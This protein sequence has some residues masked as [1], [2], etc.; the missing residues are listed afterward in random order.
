MSLAIKIATIKDC[1]AKIED[2]FKTIKA[3]LQKVD[4]SD[5]SERRN[6]VDKLKSDFKLLSVHFEAMKDEVDTIKDENTYKSYKDQLTLVKLEIK[7]LEEEFL[8]KQNK[9]Y[10]TSNLLLE[11]VNIEMKKTGQM[12]VQQAFDRGDKAVDGADK[13]INNI[14]KKVKSANEIANEIQIEQAK[15]I[16]KLTGTRKDLKEINSSLKRSDANIKTMLTMY[17]TDKL[18]MCMIVLIVL[19]IITIIIIGAVGGDTKGNFNVPH[20]IFVSNTN[21]TTATSRRL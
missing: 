5:T 9:A 21:T 11:D 12:T 19:I 18:I 2:K 4:S 1:N 7:K 14:E 20:D 10:Q 8:N 6:I 16:E 13:I 15:Q 3:N 17:A